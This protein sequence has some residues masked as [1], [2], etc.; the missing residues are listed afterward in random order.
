M[1]TNAATVGPPTAEELARLL[2]HDLRTPLNAVRGFADL[3][4]AGAAGPV[5]TAQAEMLG[6]IARAGRA[7]ERAVALAQQ[8]GERPEADPG[9]E[10]SVGLPELLVACGF[11]LAP[12]TPQL[13][14]RGAASCWRRLL[15]LCRA[16]LMGE[17]EP[18]LPLSAAVCAGAHGRL[19]LV[20]ER[21]DIHERWEPSALREQLIRQLAAGLGL[22]V[23]SQAPHLPLRLQVGVAEGGMVAR[24]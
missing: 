5:A 11:V 12:A 22:F 8:V 4:L 7:L 18:A 16:H 10:A 24:T 19:E 6:E 15:H 14:L 20:M 9:D 23:T 3:L 17:V 1:S 21:H 13:A 2:A